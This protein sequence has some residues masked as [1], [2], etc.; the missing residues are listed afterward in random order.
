MGKG[1]GEVG[2]ERDDGKE[3]DENKSRGALLLGYKGL[4]GTQAEHGSV[5]GNNAYG[6]TQDQDVGRCRSDKKN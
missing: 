4:Q 2:R 3:E 1:S 6:L 5:G